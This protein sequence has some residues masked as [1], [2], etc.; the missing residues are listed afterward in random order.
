MYWLIVQGRVWLVDIFKLCYLLNT[1][2]LQVRKVVKLTEFILAVI[3]FV[4]E[5]DSEVE[6]ILVPADV[7]VELTSFLELA[8][9]LAGAGVGLSI[10]LVLCPSKLGFP[11]ENDPDFDPGVG[12]VA[13]LGVLAPFAYFSSNILTVP[14]PGWCLTLSR[15]PTFDVTFHSNFCVLTLISPPTE[16]NQ[17]KKNWLVRN[18]WSFLLIINNLLGLRLAFSNE[19][20]RDLAF[21]SNF[22]VSTFFSPPA[23][24][25]WKSEMNIN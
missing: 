22:W 4:A 15:E 14:P 17:R 18:S 16:I 1:C 25:L 11:F 12:V 13:G 5:F 9:R 2:N 23:N 24:R 6:L 19:P 8:V 7:S 21:H 3:S 20:T 10:E